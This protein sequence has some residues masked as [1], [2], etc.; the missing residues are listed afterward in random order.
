MQLRFSTEHPL[1]VARNQV[2]L[3]SNAFIRVLPFSVDETQ[4]FRIDALVLSA[5]IVAA[6]YAQLVELAVRSIREEEQNDHTRP[7]HLDVALFQHAWSIVDQIYNIQPSSG[8]SIS[9]VRTSTTF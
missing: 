1:N 6:T 2:A 9:R 7:A 3:P 4:R 8:P 5:R